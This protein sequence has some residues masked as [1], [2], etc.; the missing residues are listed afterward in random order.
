MA[1]HT[2]PET[3]SSHYIESACARLAA[4]KPVR[5]SLPIWGRLHIDR[6]MPF[7]CIFRRPA[8]GDAETPRLVTSQASYLL[9]SSDRGL[10]QSLSS[11]VYETAATLSRV[12]GGFL[13]LELW[14]APSNENGPADGAAAVKP[15]FKI[16]APRRAQLTATVDVLEQAL[17][18]TRILKRSAD[19]S[20]VSSLRVA[21][22]GL[23]PLLSTAQR[24][25]LGVEALGLEIKP[26]YRNKQTGQAY[27]IV[28]HEL[29]RQLYRALERAFF[30]F[31]RSNTTQAPAHY[32]VLGRR[33]LVKA[34]WAADRGLAEVSNAFDFLLQVTPVNTDRAWSAFQRSRYERK[35]SFTYRPRTVAPPLLK[36]SL[37]A[38]PLE[39]VEDPLIAQLF[40]EKQDELDRQ[41]T[42][43]LDRETPRFVYGSLQLFGGV[44][45]P[46]LRLAEELLRRLPPHT[47]DDS[48]GDSVAAE[49]FAQRAGEEI[50]RLRQAYPE[51]SARV[52]VR[53]DINGL[54]VSH[55][56]LLVGQHTNIPASRVEALIQHE[57]GTHVITYHNGRAQPFKQLYSGLAGY[58]ELQE[59]LAVLSEYLVGGLSRPRLRL[60]AA[61][62]VA[63]RRMI[64]GASFVEVF[65]ELAREWEISKYT[66]FVV[67]MRVYRGG[68]FTKDAVYLR[69]LVRLLRYLADGGSLEPLFVGKIGAAHV[70]IIEELLLRKVLKPAPLHPSYLESTEVL[71][72]LKR[73]SKT[74]SVFDLIP[75]RKQR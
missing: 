47:R 6:Q 37:Y 43:L 27:P 24:A 4:N 30:E 19:V 8:N 48:Q 39:R 61:R 5:R 75:R 18:K 21:P 70:P 35:P 13:L 9:A 26:V 16:I 38:I 3:I 41:L 23:A 11:L 31:A 72:R 51:L 15:A 50:A 34:V 28:L 7:L 63:V 25:E 66:A 1:T 57:V 10:R 62:V 59:G 67:T 45:D 64:D 55:G 68:G 20:V 22:P 56:N 52:E 71:E 40:R 17:R 2:R 65:R 42:M 46:T 73:V 49:Q 74:N 69:G 54:M 14:P 12:L 29:R 32:H 44:D 36:R 58:E 60:L 53:Q 33:A